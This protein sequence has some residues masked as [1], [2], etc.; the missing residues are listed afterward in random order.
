MRAELEEGVGRLDVELTV[1]GFVRQARQLVLQLRICR[2]ICPAINAPS[3]GI[4]VDLSLLTNMSL[5]RN[6]AR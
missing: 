4:S 1:E 3:G 2:S 6:L 5:R